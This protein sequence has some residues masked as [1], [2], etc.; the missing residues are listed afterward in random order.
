MNRQLKAATAK[1]PLRA[2]RGTARAV[3]VPREAVLAVA[4]HRAPAGPR[5][6]ADPSPQKRKPR[7]PNA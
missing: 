6:Y 3:A 1:C 4:V 7:H 2:G 5:A